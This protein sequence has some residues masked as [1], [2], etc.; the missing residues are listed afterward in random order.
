MQRKRESYRYRNR[1]CVIITYR[2]STGTM[3]TSQMFVGTE[4]KSCCKKKMTS[5]RLKQLFFDNVTS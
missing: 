4:K 3:V 5:K 2:C 1:N